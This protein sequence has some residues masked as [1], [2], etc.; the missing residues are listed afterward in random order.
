MTIVEFLGAN[1]FDERP[2]IVMPLLKNGNA[3]HYVREHP[4]CDILKFVRVNWGLINCLII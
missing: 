1:V 4:Y 2:F 3:R